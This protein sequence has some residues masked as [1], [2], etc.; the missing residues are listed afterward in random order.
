MPPE[1]VRS[2]LEA[3]KRQLVAAGCETPMLDARILLQH[4][5][6]LSREDIIMEPERIILTPLAAKFAELLARRVTHEPVSRILGEREFY[7]RIFRVTPD[8]L[9]PR[10]DTETLIDAALG[11]LKPDARIL[12][13][14]TG[15]GA[16]AITLLA[17]SPEATGLATDMS[18]AALAV[19]EA[20]ARELGVA[21]RLAFALGDWFGPVEQH[22]D[23][24]VSNP[25]YIRQGD[26]AGL[27]SD[28]RDFDPLP[29]LSGGQ[30]GLDAYRHIAKDA[31]GALEP[32][33]MVL[34]EIGAG[35]EFDVTA[36][37]E[38][39]GFSPAGRFSDIGGHV[40]CLSFAAA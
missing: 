5:A 30:D 11:L 13:L 25:P 17:E 24:I 35:Q 1:T 2:L 20:N 6:G 32:L 18:P 34:V 36:I 39:T 9:D 7:G 27:A 10:P 16:I 19:A 29:A 40:R 4:V 37:F 14:G 3:A 21:D 15:S 33:G 38:V 12:D 31:R 26:I 28:V 22:F 23:L 8:V